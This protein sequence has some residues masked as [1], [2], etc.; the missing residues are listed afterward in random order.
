MAH[1]VIKTLVFAPDG[2]S[3]AT[4]VSE[5]AKD[6]REKGHTLSVITT[7]PHYNADPEALE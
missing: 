3:T 5:L 4:I 6:I 7:I 2:V 1:V